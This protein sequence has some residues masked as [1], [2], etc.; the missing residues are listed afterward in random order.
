MS[1]DPASVPVLPTHVVQTR[2]ALHQL[3][4]FVLAPRRHDHTDRLGLRATPGGFG[5]TWFDGPD[6]RERVR[7]EGARL[8]VELALDGD[9]DAGVGERRELVPSTV[10]AACA[11]V[12]IPY[13]EVWFEDFHDPLEAWDPERPLDLDDAAARALGAWFAFGTTVLDE[14]RATPGAVD[15]SIV[16]LWPEHLDPA[17]ELGSADAGERASYGASPGDAD[18][19]E[20]YL[21]VAPWGEVGDDEFWNAES[22]GGSVLPYAELRAADDPAA[23]ALAFLRRGHELL[24][25]G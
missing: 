7:M 22:F 16:Q 23:V 10:A 25:A 5:T 12:G 18:H 11:F 13:R 14:L 17:C 1:S 20:P 15:P 4:F 9:E 3:A 6:G 21:Y 24:T 2:A 8:V 19:D